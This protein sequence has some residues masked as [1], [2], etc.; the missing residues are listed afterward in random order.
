MIRRLALLLTIVS[1][2]A[3][4]QARPLGSTTTTRK[5]VFIAGFGPA[6][7]IAPGLVC[8]DGSVARPALTCVAGTDAWEC[9]D[10][11][12]AVVAVTPG[13]GVV[14]EDGPWGRAM[15]GWAE[16]P[17]AP[18]VWA[19]TADHTIV[20]VGRPSDA[21]VS[22][23]ERHLFADNTGTT[24]GLLAYYRADA[25]GNDFRCSYFTDAGRVDAALLAQASRR[26]AWQIHTCRRAGDTF[27][28]RVNGATGTASSSGAVLSTPAVYAR[29]GSSPTTS[30]LFGKEAW[31][32]EFDC[33]LTDASLARLEAQVYG[34]RASD[35]RP[36]TTTR[37]GTA[38]CGDH[39]LGDNA[40]C[41]SASGLE[42][43]GP[44]LNHATN[45]TNPT[46]WV[47]HIGTPTITGPTAEGWW[48]YT[49]DDPASRETKYIAQF[50]AGSATHVAYSA[51]CDLAPGTLAQARV[52]IAV[53]AGAGVV[54]GGTCAH[55]L[56]APKRYSCT[57]TV[58]GADATTIVR[59][60]FEAGTLAA[61]DTGSVLVRQCQVETTA[62][63]GRRCDA[64]ASP[65]T[66]P[67]DTHTVS[68]AGWPVSGG[69]AEVD[70]TP[71]S[72]VTGFQRIWST[73]FS[74]D[75]R[76]WHSFV[77]YFGAL[78]LEAGDDVTSERRCSAGGD[79]GW[80]VG[81][82]Y[83]LRVEWSGGLVR[84]WRDGVPLAGGTI[85]IPRS[86]SSTVQ[87]GHINGIQHAR[88]AISNLRCGR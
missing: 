60:I 1:A 2:P 27:T 4:V 80:V 59:V 6:G 33:A 17:A 48:T 21:A 49:D 41:V 3:W 36:V 70:F 54:T 53:T 84:F 5:T 28:A 8:T 47:A 37:P 9:R 82:T 83:R 32:F 64:G 86:L 39:Q 11:N 30:M 16:I 22:N 25:N 61:T 74:G 40:A 73:T 35:G 24:A 55:A 12:G 29:I 7:S 75:P 67:G 14:Y 42:G 58:A 85:P 46:L 10:Q 57:A 63:P 78:C 66:C 77:L 23:Q 72:T 71:S 65:T 68:S 69:S 50:A 62:T 31:V 15:D 79:P 81:Q 87:I 13:A 18:E 38:W 45:S 76:N 56:T 19:G 52:S 43:E 88:G 26:G 34:S 51:T 44:A 20:A